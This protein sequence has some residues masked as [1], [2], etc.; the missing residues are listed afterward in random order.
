MADKFE[1]FYTNVSDPADHAYSITPDSTTDLPF[2]TRAVYVGSTGNLVVSMVTDT[3]NTFIT[4][5][6]IPA[7]SI[8]PIRV[9]RISEASTAGN[10]IGMY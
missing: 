3:A 9:K 8:L 2:S 4:F 5:A 6:S 1:K 7:G 10:L